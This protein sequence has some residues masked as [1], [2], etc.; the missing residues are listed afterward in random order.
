MSIMKRRWGKAWGGKAPLFP[1]RSDAAL[2]TAGSWA[3]QAA[4]AAVV[5]AGGSAC[6]GGASVASRR[7]HGAVAARRAALGG[8]TPDARGVGPGVGRGAAE[9]GAVGHGD[10]L[11][12]SRRVAQRPEIDLGSL[13]V[14]AAADAGAVAARARP[15]RVLGCRCGC[16][17]AP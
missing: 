13:S 10:A 17:Y 7:W 16:G 12:G 3:I 11:R 8:R 5:A 15:R 1:V 14:A 4:A 6:G 2:R 9:V